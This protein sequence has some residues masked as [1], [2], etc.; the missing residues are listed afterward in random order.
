MNWLPETDPAHGINEDFLAS[1]GDLV[2]ALT[3]LAGS[4]NPRSSKRRDRRRLVEGALSNLL[5]N[6]HATGQLPP[7]APVVPVAA[8][9]PAPRTVTRNVATAL[10]RLRRRQYCHCGECKW[11]LGNL[12]WDRIFNEKF[13]DPAYYGGIVVRRNSTLAGAG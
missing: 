9:A 12:R 10:G 2:S 7:A 8:L 13:A 11:C 3:D 5:R 6:I 4:S 1:T